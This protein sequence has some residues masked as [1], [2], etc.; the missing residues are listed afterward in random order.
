MAIPAIGIAFILGVL[1]WSGMYVWSSRVARARAVGATGAAPADPRHVFS[2]KRAGLRQA[3]PHSRLVLGRESMTI[4]VYSLR[5]PD[6]EVLIERGDVV[7]AG[8]RRGIGSMTVTFEVTGM[9]QTQYRFMAKPSGGLRAVLAE[10][11][12]LDDE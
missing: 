9:R 12:W 8:V 11:G 6:A 4:E 7:R 10:L 2:G 3:V 5:Q 1:Y